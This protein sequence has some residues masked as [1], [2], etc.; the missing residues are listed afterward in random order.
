MACGLSAGGSDLSRV[1]GDLAGAVELMDG[2]V[3]ECK[4]I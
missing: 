1:Q 3:L 4:R 2:L